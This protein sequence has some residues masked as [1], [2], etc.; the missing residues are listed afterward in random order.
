MINL[1][2]AIDQLVAEHNIKKFVSTKPWSDLN[3]YLNMTK[4]YLSSRDMITY[5]GTP[6]EALLE[7]V[8][9]QLMEPDKKVGILLDSI[10]VVRIIEQLSTVSE[11]YG[12]S[13]ILII[14]NNQ[15]ESSEK[16]SLLSDTTKN[17]LMDTLLNTGG[18]SIDLNHYDDLFYLPK[19]PSE[20]KSDTIVYFVN[21]YNVFEY[22]DN[23]MGPEVR[24]I[25]DSLEE[26]SD[27][28]DNLRENENVIL[29]VGGDNL[30]KWFKY[31]HDNDK[32][33]YIH[34]GAQYVAQSIANLRSDLKVILIDNYENYKVDFIPSN[35]ECYLA[36][37]N[38][39][40]L[41]FIKDDRMH[42]IEAN[43]DGDLPDKGDDYLTRRWRLAK[44]LYPDI[45]I[46][47]DLH[48][49]I[50]GSYSLTDEPGYDEGETGPQ[51]LISSEFS[52]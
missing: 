32:N 31:Y 16:Y 19:I 34:S 40:T 26:L 17:I 9:I 51:E 41:S 18:A 48:D 22:P 2:V 36:T 28:I 42:I 24:Y 44:A 5:H 15:N 38:A 20:Y 37:P 35:M 7:A 13:L 39:E 11:L 47:D 33:I 27:Q 8:G 52:E 50:L 12:L 14:G 1:A 29:V 23:L 3:S 25:D 43:P 46:P 30:I 45:K 4:D 10:E 21:G 49:Q 6:E